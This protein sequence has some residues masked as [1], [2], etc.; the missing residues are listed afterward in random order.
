MVSAFTGGD[1]LQA[2]LRGIAERAG[3]STTVRVGFLEGSQESD[4]T[5]MPMIAAIQEFGAPG[6]G[7][8]PR[9]FMRTAIATHKGEWAAKLGKALV[10]QN[11]DAT[12]A[13]G[14]VGE[15]I[16]DDLRQ[17]IRDV[18][19]P[20]LAH[21]T[22][23]RKGGGTEAELAKSRANVARLGVAGPDK[24][25]IDTG[26]MLGSIKSEVTDGTD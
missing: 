1:K 25:L 8:P 2:Y 17:S 22:V 11:Y 15:V 6:A 7:I 21:S 5:S 9:P 23:L 10:A 14:L 20:P 18:T 3:K 16:A 24:P 26:T 13:L 4:G 19:S 12:A